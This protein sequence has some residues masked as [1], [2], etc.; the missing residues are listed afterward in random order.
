M[1]SREFNTKYKDY[2]QE[3]HYGLAIDNP[4]FVRWLDVKFQN[5]IKKDNFKYSQIKAKFGMG[6]FYC[7]GLDLDQ[8]E[9]REVEERIS[10]ICKI[11]DIKRMI[12]KDLFQRYDNSQEILEYV[13]TNDY[14]R[15]YWEL[16][17]KLN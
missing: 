1:T 17:N 8:N 5:F 11:D 9:I 2:L 3:G 10:T 14:I 7:D 13:T 4:S 12:K 6:R 16:T 15:F